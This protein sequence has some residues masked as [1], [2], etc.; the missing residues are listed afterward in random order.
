MKG[1]V[2][3]FRRLLPSGSWLEDDT[4]WKGSERR[5]T[6]ATATMMRKD[7]PL[8]ECFSSFDTLAI[9]RFGKVTESPL[10]WSFVLVLERPSGM[11]FPCKSTMETSILYEWRFRKLPLMVGCGLTLVPPT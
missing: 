5:V 11:M 9:L 6:P 8:F 3:I 4:T 1:D 7:L 10:I 2:V